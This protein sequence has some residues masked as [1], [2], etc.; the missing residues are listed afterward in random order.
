MKARQYKKLCKK[1]MI[2]LVKAGWKHGNFSVDESGC[3]HR[4]RRSYTSVYGWNTFS[5]Y[6]GECDW[7]DAWYMLY[8]RV[9]DLTADWENYHGEDDKNPYEKSVRG[10]RN[11]LNW[12]GNKEHLEV[13]RHAN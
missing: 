7:F 8:S 4:G 2:I 5:D 13:I 1:A 3:S 12:C 11:I 9:A 6:N 10:T